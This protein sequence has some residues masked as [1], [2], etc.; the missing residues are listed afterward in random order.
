MLQ[1]HGLYK[2]IVTNV[3]KI[4]NCQ[5]PMLAYMQSCRACW[6]GYLGADR[7]FINEV[8][9]MASYTIICTQ[10]TSLTNCIHYLYKYT[11]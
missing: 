6:H 1:H 9:Y 5:V 8:F 11:V 7:G 3:I 4:F 10:N 2:N